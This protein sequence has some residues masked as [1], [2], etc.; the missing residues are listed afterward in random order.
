M[1]DLGPRIREGRGEE[2]RDPRFRSV[3]VVLEAYWDVLLV[4]VEVVA[5]AVVVYALW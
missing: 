4:V 3:K 2:P 1:T 5:L